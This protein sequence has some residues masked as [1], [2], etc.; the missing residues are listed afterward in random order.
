MVYSAIPV[1]TLQVSDACIQTVGK[2][3]WGEDTFQH[4]KYQ[5]R[6]G[7]STESTEPSQDGAS[8]G[9]HGISVHGKSHDIE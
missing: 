9:N 3:R 7:I 5:S 2:S 4:P 1:R 6:S 8:P